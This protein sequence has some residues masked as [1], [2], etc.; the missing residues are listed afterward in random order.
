[1]AQ[2]P[3]LMFDAPQRVLEIGACPR[4]VTPGGTQPSPRDHRQYREQSRREFTV[5]AVLGQQ[6]LA[7]VDA[8]LV[9]QRVDQWD[10]PG[11]LGVV[12]VRPWMSSAARPS[13]SAPRRSPRRWRATPRSQDARAN[14]CGEPLRSAWRMARDRMCSATS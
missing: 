14:H 7:L 4:V 1:M 6:R 8:A 2:A 13:A 12:A 5:H 3:R 9:G 10:E 11:A